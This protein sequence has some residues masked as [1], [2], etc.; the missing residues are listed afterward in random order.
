MHL[1]ATEAVM[2]LPAQKFSP[3]KAPVVVRMKMKG[4]NAGAK[5]SGLRIPQY[6]FQS[7]ALWRRRS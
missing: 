4:A 1:T 7:S 5:A 3:T 2:V 6:I